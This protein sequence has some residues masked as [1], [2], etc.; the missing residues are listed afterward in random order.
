MPPPIPPAVALAQPAL[1]PL[2]RTLLSVSDWPL[3]RSAQAS[4]PPLRAAWLLLMT[5]SESDS[6]SVAAMAPPEP[7][8]GTG[9]VPLA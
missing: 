8:A 5:T 6:D 4:A 2:T 3:R 1:L 9:Q 7:V